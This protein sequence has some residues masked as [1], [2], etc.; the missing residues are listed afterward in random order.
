M[1]LNQLYQELEELQARYSKALNN[2]AQLE[3]RLHRLEKENEVLKQ[4]VTRLQKY[5][6][7]L[8]RAIEIAV[9]IKDYNAQ[10]RHLQ[11]VLE[12]IKEKWGE[13]NG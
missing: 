8:L 10:T 6:N 9:Q 13:V 4:E 7:T 12:K 5:A 2:I 11:A 3:K 1:T